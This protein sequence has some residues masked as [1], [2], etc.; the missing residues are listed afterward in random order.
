VSQSPSPSPFPLN[1]IYHVNGITAYGLFC[2]DTCCT[3]V[4]CSADFRLWRKRW[5]VPPKRRFTYELHDDISQK[6]T[7]FVSTAARTSNPNDKVVTS[8]VLDAAIL[9]LLIGIILPRM[10]WDW[11]RLH[12]KT[13]I[14]MTIG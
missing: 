4:S 7:T 14:I 3:P 5:Y 2:L 1:P 9:V 12:D 8:E 6:M 10:P 11:L 13:Q